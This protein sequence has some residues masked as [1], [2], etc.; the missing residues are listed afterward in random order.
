MHL[1]IYTDKDFI[2]KGAKYNY[3]PLM[4]PFWGECDSS[5]GHIDIGRFDDYTKNGNIFFS[6]ASIEESDVVILPSE[7]PERGDYPEA[8]L[9]LQLAAIWEK[10]VIVFFNS[11]SMQK[12]PVD[13]AIIF[14]TSFYVSEKKENEFALPGWNIDFLSYVPE[15]VIRKK[16]TVPTVSYCGYVD[17]Y[18]LFGKSFIYQL[19]RNLRYG[20]DSNPGKALRGKAI[21]KLR[22]SL[23]VNTEFIIRS[24]TLQYKKD[25]AETLRMEYVNNIMNA[26][27][28]LVVRGKGNFSY[29]LYEVLSCGRIPVFVNTDCVLP[30]DHIID[31]QKYMVWVESSEI[32]KI[33]EKVAKFHS[34]L[35][36]E[37]FK[38]LQ[39]SIRQLYD[40]WIKPTGFYANLW[41]CLPS[42]F[43]QK[44]TS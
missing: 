34:S 4:Y 42:N 8:Q 24:K 21:R 2:R 38:Q 30:F 40:E 33:A 19:L 10:P 31:W 14:R 36:E 18:N 23:L 3:I 1:K 15:Y 25:S 43:L 44:K 28:A 9:L 12:I 6:L 35:S 13:N 41:R 27:Y 17:Y 7:W 20:K 5:Q 11:D 22:K 37:E 39:L 32:N 26:D 29:R 16:R